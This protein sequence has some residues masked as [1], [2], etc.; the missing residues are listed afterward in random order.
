M[1]LNY[2]YLDKQMA[3]ESTIFQTLSSYNFRY[4]IRYD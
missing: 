2:F 4:I 1:N 3:L